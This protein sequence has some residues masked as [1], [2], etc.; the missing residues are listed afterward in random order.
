MNSVFFTMS[1]LINK[2]LYVHT[3]Y[4]TECLFYEMIT[5]CF[6]KTHN[7]QCM[8]IRSCTI[9][10]FDEP[11]DSSVNEVTVIQIDINRHQKSRAFFYIVSKLAFYDLILG[12]SWMKQNEIILNADRVSLMI[13]FTETIIQNRE[14][15]AE[16][17]F[18]HVMMSAMFFTNLIQ[19][20]EK[21]QKKIEVF[22]ASMTDIEKALTS[23]KKTDSR[24]ILLDH[25]HKF[26]NVFDRTMTEKLPPLRREGTDHQIELKGVN[27]KESKVPWGPLYNMMKE[28]LLVLHKTLTE[29]LN[30]QFIQVSNSSAAAS[31]LFIWKSEG[32]LW[33][34]VNYCDLNW[35]TQ[36]NHYSLSLIY[37]TLQNIR[38]A[39]WYIKLNVIVTFHKI[40]IAAEDK[41]KTVF[42]MRYRLYEWMMTSFELANVSS[43]FQRYINWALQNFLNK[44]CSVYVNHILIFTDEL[45]HQHRNHVWKIL[46]QLWEVGL[47]IDIDKCEFEVKSIKYLE[48]IL[49]VRKNIQMNSQ[50]MKTIMNWQAFKSVKSVQSFIDFAN[51]YW[52]FI[53]NF[54]NL[55]MS[56]MALIQKNTL[57]KW[58]EKVNQ[59]FMKLKVMFISAS[60]LVSF[61]H[62]CTTMMKTDFSDWCIDETLLQLINNVWRLCVYYSKK[63]APAECNYEIYDKEMLI[64]IQCLKEWDAELRSVLSF[65][66]CT[67]HKNLKYFMTVKKLTEQQMRW[68]LV[69]LWYNF[70]ILYLLSK[71]NERTD[72]LLRQKQN[73]LMNLSDDR[74]Q[75][76]MTQMIHSEMIS[77]PI[78][79]ASMTIA[80]ISVSVLVQAQNLFDEITDLKQMWVNAEAKD[81]LYDEL[82][83]TIHKKQRSF[84]TVLKVRVFIMKCFLS[85]EEKLLFCERHWMPSSKLLC[86]KLIQYTHDSTMTEHSKRDVT[87]ALLSWQFFWPEML[88]NVCTFCWNCDKCCMNNSWKDRWQGFLK[89]LSVL[90]QIWQKIF[91]DFV[92]DLL[93]SESCTNLLII[94]DCLSKK[95]LLES[96]KNMT[97]EWVTQT[98]VQHFYRALE[99]FITIV[100]DWDTQFVSRLWK[101]VCQLLKIVQRMFTAYHLKTDKAIKQMNQNVELYICMFSNYSQNNLASLLLMAELVINNH[102]FVSTEVSFF[103][104]FH[105]YHMKPLQLLEKLKPVQSVKSSVQKAD[106]VVQKMKEVTE[107]AQM[108]MALTQQV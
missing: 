59:S 36:K 102:D 85:D 28:K 80:D 72:A 14:A 100:S 34:C 3:L 97:A 78:Q 8:K 31:V 95:V 45:L 69:L 33:F 83:Q 91:I 64:I 107:W 103:F 88:Q 23:Q 93:L 77:K 74:V 19:K 53:K 63:N 43:I 106:Q 51:F 62:T 108:T 22:S 10:E 37:E 13:E 6:A 46:L 52:K 44:F 56:M 50:K 40:W 104:L 89:P 101:R 21:K 105:E 25:Y 48:F 86:T 16:S 82:C 24:T 55:I 71:Q 26:L 73:V 61:D 96:C 27:E 54:F 41:W 11:S 9:T 79:A 20:K 60:I 39:Q 4:N 49:K 32:E 58:T 29:L 42:H 12:L 15:S 1:T 35:I 87:D 30:K 17:E 76:H 70:F 18:N 99:L 7:L 38:W 57:F 68:S 81:E 66:I 2:K 67:N 75:H 5:S 47:Q 94:T 92:V 84:S 90:K 65:Q 98:F